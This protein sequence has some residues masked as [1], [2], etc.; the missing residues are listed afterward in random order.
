MDAWYDT[1]PPIN[2][3][4]FKRKGRMLIV[5]SK[6]NC[7]QCIR[8]KNGLTKSGIEYQEINISKDDE[9]KEFLLSEG[10]RTVPQVY[11]GGRCLSLVEV[12]TLL[13]G[14]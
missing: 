10:H 5:Y 14:K 13:G 2:L 12:K 3:Y 6:D 1:L 4:S 7:P 9:A 8:L 11:E